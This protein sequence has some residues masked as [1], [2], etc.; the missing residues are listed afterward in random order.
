MCRRKCSTFNI[1]VFWFSFFDWCLWNSC[2]KQVFIYFSFGVALQREKYMLVTEQGN[3][4]SFLHNEFCTLPC[5][6]ILL[7]EGSC[8]NCRFRSINE[9]TLVQVIACLISCQTCRGGFFIQLCV[10]NY[11]HVVVGV[12]WVATRAFKCSGKILSTK[13]GLS[14]VVGMTEVTNEI[15]NR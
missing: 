11:L 1:L 2:R 5:A 12:F 3:D 9:I 4:R 6:R 7:R 14:E 10:P 13:L 8:V 15:F